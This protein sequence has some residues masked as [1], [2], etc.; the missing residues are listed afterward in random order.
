MLTIGELADFAGVSTRTVRF[1]HQRGLIAEPERDAS[2]YRR[3]GAEDVIRLSRIAALARA[4]VPLG[5][6]AEMLDAPAESFGE[7]VRAV[8]ADVKAEIARL[9]AVRR[10]LATLESADR[11]ALPTELGDAVEVL[12]S[13]DAEDRY[14]DLYRDAWIL[15]F[16]LYPAAMQEWISSQGSHVDPGY[17][18]LLVRMLQAPD[19]DPDDPVLDEIA[20]DSA[21]WM[22]A[23]WESQTGTWQSGFDD[24]RLND[25]MTAQWIMTPA[26]ERLSGRIVDVLAERGLDVGSIAPKSAAQP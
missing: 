16:V 18:D 12:R 14:V 19:L 4:G 21:D 23:N 11:L 3:Y 20:R 15:A 1:Y 7:Q 2:G 8:D 5:R 22:E 9:R 25:I 13:S 10:E 17:L 26:W 24:D 6:I